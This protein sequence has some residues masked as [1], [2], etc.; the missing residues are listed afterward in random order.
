MNSREDVR[1][2]F[3]SPADFAHWNEA[4]FQKYGNER[5]YNHPNVLIRTI[6][7]RRIDAIIALLNVKETDSVLDAG[8]GEGFLFS[9]LPNSTRRVGADISHTAL[10]IAQTRSYHNVQWLHADICALPYAS[11]TFD[12]IVCSEVIEHIPEP[13]KL[14]LELHR[15][16]KPGGRLVMTIPYEARLD[17][18]KDIVLRSR[19]GRLMF[20]NIPRRTEWHLT[21]YDMNL[22]LHQLDGRLTVSLQKSL[23]YRFLALGFAVLCIKET[24]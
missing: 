1:P 24:R 20:S 21:S 18:I 13:S 2:A 16:L 8:T 12:K 3:E 19:L 14:I 7:R 22:L 11:D 5:L 9:V 10:R 17:A 15:V 23:P 6:Q 4:M